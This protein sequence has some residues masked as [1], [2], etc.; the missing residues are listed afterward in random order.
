MSRLRIAAFF[1]T[2]FAISGAL[3]L[4][5]WVGVPVLFIGGIVWLI[6]IQEVVDL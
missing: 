5:M 6:S 3:Y 4:S 2:P 1:L